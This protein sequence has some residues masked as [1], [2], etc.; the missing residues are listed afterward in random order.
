MWN[1]CHWRLLYFAESK[2]PSFVSFVNE[3][4]PAK[5]TTFLELLDAMNN[6]RVYKFASKCGSWNW[7]AIAIMLVCCR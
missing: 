7:K 5:A 2:V 4:Y 6:E 3:A 1:R